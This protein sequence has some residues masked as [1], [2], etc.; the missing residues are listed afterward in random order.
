MARKIN[1]LDPKKFAGL[2]PGYHRDGGGLYLQVSTAGTKSWIFRFMLNGRAREMGLGSLL[3]VSLKDAREKAADCRR[4][5]ANKRDPIEVRDALHRQQALEAARTKTFKECAEA[6][7]DSKKG[8]WRNA[9]HAAQWA[10]TLKTYAFPVFG[11]LSV[12]DIDKPLIM[13]VLD[14]IW[15]EKTETASRLR[16]RIETVLNWAMA[17][18]YREEGLNPA[19]WRG[20]LDKAGLGRR[21]EVAPVT[22][23]PALPYEEIPAF[24]KELRTRNGIAPRALEFLILTATR[25]GEATGATWAEVD[26][27]KA[28]W[29]IPGARMKA[30]RDHRVPLSIAAVEVLKDIEKVRQNDYVF[31]G[32]RINKPLTSASCM[33]VLRKMKRDDITVHGFRSS[34]R[35]W[36]AEQTAYANEVAEAALAHVVKDKAE[37]AYRRGDM[38]EKRAKLMQA[39]AD[40]CAKVPKPASVTPIRGKAK[41][42]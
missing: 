2:K 21:S 5:L 12:Q 16:G 14:P 15:H 9:K 30:K 25:A 10:S 8:K 29:T 42:S 26:L 35:D 20:N 7:I 4:E 28:V 19:R 3:A 40:Y 37:A 6:Y 24:M 31:P 11:H 36:C 32:Q 33:K 34:F 39:W 17:R 27:D 41:N 18:G 22:H 38:L 13:R 1:E 23:H